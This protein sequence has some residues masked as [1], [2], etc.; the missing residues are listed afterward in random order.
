MKTRTED[1]LAS[2]GCVPCEGGVQPWGPDE[3]RSQL[4]SLKGWSL[5]A[6]GK[7]IS[8]SWK[9]TDFRQAMKLANAIAEIAETDQHHPDIHLTRYRCLNVDLTTHAI[10]GLSENDFVIAAKIS[11]AAKEIGQ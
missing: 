3:T 10:G 11:V 9:L 5:T 8:R 7:M 1:E 6:D 2:A 4:Q